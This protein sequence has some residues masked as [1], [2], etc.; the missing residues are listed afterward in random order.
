MTVLVKRIEIGD[1]NIGWGTGITYF[2]YRHTHIFYRP[3]IYQNSEEFIQKTASII[4][5]PL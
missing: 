2:I 3:Q 4:S 1:V 5:A